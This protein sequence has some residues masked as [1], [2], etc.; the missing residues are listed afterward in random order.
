MINAEDLN[1]GDIKA[2]YLVDGMASG[3]GACSLMAM[4][5]VFVECLAS[6]KVS[7]LAVTS[8]SYTSHWSIGATENDMYKNF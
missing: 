2:F 6:A 4:T 8:I 1:G 5:Y 7:N 3:L